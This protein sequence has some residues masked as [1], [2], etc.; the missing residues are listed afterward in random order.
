M[1][2]PSLLLSSPLL[3]LTGPTAVGKTAL[4]LAWAEQF[5]GEIINADSRQVY[6]HMEIGTAKPSPAERAQVPHHLFDLV[7]PDQSFSQAEYQT[8]AYATI[9]EIQGRGKLPM[10]VG[11]TGLYITSTIEGWSAPQ[12]APDLALRAEL[13]TKTKAELF[14][15]L[16]KL[17]P[18]SAETI[19]RDNPRRLIRALE[20]CIVSGQPF[21]QL[22]QKNPPPYD[23]LAFALDMPRPDLYARADQRAL[24]MIERG[25]IEET[26]H[27][28]EDLGY[29][30]KLPSFSA[31][32]YPQIAAHLR[33]EMTL[34]QTIERIQLDTHHFIRRQYT[35]I[36]GHVPASGWQWLTHDQQA[37]G[38]ITAWLEKASGSEYN[39]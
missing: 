32:G 19:D 7:D 20:V 36:R 35:W 28:T 25:W 39:S 31:L 24:T 38:Q 26:R 16:A 14:A 22:R 21:S 33:G 17:D 27:L 37:E 12:I 1:T 29:D 34:P 11:G 13:E 15:Q 9:A 3:I 18:V 4:A 5:N 8:L 10:L 23:I 30:P 2:V 6:R